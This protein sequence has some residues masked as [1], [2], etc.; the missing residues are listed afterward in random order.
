MAQN[1]KCM[2]IALLVLLW[3]LVGAIPSHSASC[4]ALCSGC[5]PEKKCC[6]QDCE[7]TGKPFALC[8][9]AD[10]TEP[11]PQ[12]YCCCY[13]G[14]PG[15]P[16]VTHFCSAKRCPTVEPSPVDFLFEDAPTKPTSPFAACDAEDTWLQLH[17]QRGRDGRLALRAEGPRVSDLRADIDLWASHNPIVE[18]LAPGA[19]GSTLI[20]LPPCS[21][22]PYPD[23]DLRLGEKRVSSDQGL[24]GHFVLRLE[25]DKWGSVASQEVVFST[26][27]ERDPE[28]LAFLMKHL[29]IGY[30]VRETYPI[31]AMLALQ[32]QGGEWEIFQRAQ[33]APAVD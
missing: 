11:S 6:T 1:S 19:S 32:I 2:Y 15:R 33:Y 26:A 31:I 12:C 23:V 22:R 30:P 7:G 29:E 27:P 10:C 4:D 24:S 8:G 5:A 14:V 18:S 17:Y 3:L 9:D 21:A 20:F 28:V 25:L 13:S 16:G